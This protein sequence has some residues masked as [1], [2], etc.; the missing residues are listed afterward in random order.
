MRT[1]IKVIFLFSLIILTM[2]LGIIIFLLNFSRGNNHF[3]AETFLTTILENDLVEKI[4]KSK[5][6]TEITRP[7]GYGYSLLIIKQ[8]G[9]EK[10]FVSVFCVENKKIIDCPPVA[11]SH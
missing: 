7:F 9:V 3:L 6:T 10:P 8:K 4:D 11:Y 5:V 1:E 2:V